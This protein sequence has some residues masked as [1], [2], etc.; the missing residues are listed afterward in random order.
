MAEKFDAPVIQTENGFSH[1]TGQYRLCL[2]RTPYFTATQ[3]PRGKRFEYSG[4]IGTASA[5]NETEG[6]TTG[7]PY[8]SAVAAAVPPL[9]TH[10]FTISDS[11]TGQGSITG[12]T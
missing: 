1:K 3:K 6:C 12:H 9:D 5:K 11:N 10:D 7:H 8:L 4:K 2:C